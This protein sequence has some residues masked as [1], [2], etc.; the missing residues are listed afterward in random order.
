MNLLLLRL[1]VVALPALLLLSSLAAL[2]MSIPAWGAG[3]HAGLSPWM[4]AAAGVV[5]A[6]PA[7]VIAAIC[8]RT[9][10]RS[11]RQAF[12]VTPVLL[13]FGLLAL[14]I[15]IA[16]ETAVPVGV[17]DPATYDRLLE[18]DASGPPGLS[19]EGADDGPVSATGFLAG[20]ALIA[21]F[22]NGVVAVSTVIYGSAIVVEGGKR[23][24]RRPDEFDAVEELL[25]GRRGPGAPFP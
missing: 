21:F 23:F 19:L 5:L 7:A 8:L 22:L 4:P 20:T 18:E 24:E 13:V 17:A 16:T 25:K 12:S 14:P 2:L 10:V 3:N 11:T 15:A 1:G 6:L 9:V